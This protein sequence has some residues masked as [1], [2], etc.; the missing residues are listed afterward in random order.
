MIFPLALPNGW[1]NWPPGMRRLNLAQVCHTWRAI[2]FSIPNLW[3]GINFEGKCTKPGSV[4]EELAMDELRRTSVAP[5]RVALAEQSIY[6]TIHRDQSWQISQVWLYLRANTH[7]WEYVYLSNQHMEVYTALSGYSFPILRSLRANV[8]LCDQL[9]RAFEDAPALS[10][11]SCY[12][13][14]SGFEDA[15][16]SSWALS[17]LILELG[18]YSISSPSLEDVLNAVLSCSRTL[19]LCRIR[20]TSED[21]LPVVSTITLFPLLENVDLEDAAVPFLEHISA[22][23]LRSVKMHIISRDVHVNHCSLRILADLTDR[24]NNCPHMRS[25]TLRGIDGFTEYAL[26]CLRR[27]PSLERLL[28]VRAED[29][30]MSI[31]PISISFAQALTRD[32][33][34]PA[35]LELLPRLTHLELDIEHCRPRQAE[36]AFLA[37]VHSRRMVV[38]GTEPELVCLTAFHMTIGT[39]VDGLN[40]LDGIENNMDDE[41]VDA[42]LSEEQNI[43]YSELETGL[44]EFNE[45]DFGI[46]TWS[47][48]QIDR[49]RG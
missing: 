15:L 40:L 13:L 33:A 18:D 1:A 48:G 17:S 39:D 30:D 3:T 14:C 8:F 47:M 42:D 38:T 5:L 37:M 27:L 31:H 20:S 24:S 16:P 2:A 49:Q 41:D 9:A 46:R 19:R 44:W 35:S 23:N 28:V 4:C 36:I 43:E 25:L 21:E 29:T 22:P 12:T 6:S 26:A 32:L 10:V 7:R 11:L 45:D 34:R